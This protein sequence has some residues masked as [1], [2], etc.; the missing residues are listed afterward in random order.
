M[1]RRTLLFPLF[2][3]VLIAAASGVGTSSGDGATSEPA[4]HLPWQEAGWSERE[5]AAHLL[6]RF[7]YGARPGDVDR[8]V[9]MGLDAWF[10]RQLAADLPEP[11]LERRLA[12]LTSLRLPA[13]EMASR[14]PGRGQVLLAAIEAGAVPEELM[15]GGE[16]REKLEQAMAEMPAAERAEL[17]RAVR[18]FARREG[19]GRPQ[20]LYEQL[21]AA[22]LLSAVYAENQLREVVTDFWFNH[23]NVSVTDPEARGFVA[24]YERDAIRPHVFADFR[25]LLG[26]SARHPATLLY[27]DN[28]RSVAEAGARKLFE[29]RRAGRRGRPERPNA[30]QGLNE[31]YAREL[32]ELHTLGVDG[33]YTQEDVVA[34]ARAFTG[35]AL[36]PPGDGR[37]RVEERLARAERRF[38]AGRLREAGFVRDGE[39]L[40]RADVHDAGA[41]TILGQRFPAGG[42]VEEG[43]RVLDLAAAHPSTARHLAEKVARRFVADDPPAS[44]VERLAGVYRASGGDLRALVAAVAESPELWDHEVR[45][46]KVKTPFELVVSALR[47]V[48][49]EVADTGALVRRLDAMGQR[50]YACSPPTGWEDR[51][52]AWVGTGSLLDRMNFASELAAGEVRGV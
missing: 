21:A 8:V 23:L 24:A 37:Q 3:F 10:A 15:A 41:K 36:V 30:P 34:V 42:G 22:K 6:D 38:G 1:T 2:L 32:L 13:A 29:P 28:A 33:G 12:P 14:F 46:A 9:A 25:T 20:E 16:R 11:E 40:F 5:A 51:A 27:L 49:A 7:A 26:A 44:L 19:Y 35:W 31:N 43:E 4:V 50:P 47:A 45:G 18:D 39:F 52:E 48:D 17:R